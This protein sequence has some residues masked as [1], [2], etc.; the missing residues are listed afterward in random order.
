MKKIG[1]LLVLLVF[2][3]SCSNDDSDT[4]KQPDVINYY[5][6][7]IQHA[8]SRFANDP[9]S[10][11]F[12]YIFRKDNTFSKIRRYENINTTLTGTFKILKKD[13]VTQFILT[14]PKYNPLIS[15]CTNDLIESFNLESVYLID[16]ARACDRSYVFK[17]I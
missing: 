12:S 7:W 14:Y 8:E 16:E 10:K 13:N 15:N 9:S 6:T 17:K 1:L 2:L 5:G 11:Q 3:E 4:K